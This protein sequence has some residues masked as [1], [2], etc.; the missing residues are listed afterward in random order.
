MENLFEK[1][2]NLLEEG[3]SRVE[4]ANLLD[5]QKSVVN[6]YANPRNWEKFKSKQQTQT[7]RLNFEETIL[8]V[9]DQA[10]SASNICDLIGIHHTNVN[11]QRVLKFLE[12]KGINPK[13]KEIQSNRKP[14]GF[15]TKETIFTENSTYQRSRLK[16]KLIEFKIKENKCEICGNTHWLEQPIPLQI[17]HINGINNDNRVENLQILCPNC[18]ALTD[19]YCGKNINIESIQTDN[20]ETKIEHEPKQTIDFEESFLKEKLY[21]A[22]FKNF[23]DLAK[24]L[25]ISRKTLQ[26]ICRK[27]GLP[28]S[29][30]EMGLISK[31][32]LQPVVCKHC[33][34][35]FRPAR[36]DANYCSIACFRK[37]NN[38]PEE[39]T[40]IP[41]DILLLE[42]LKHKSMLSLAKTFG[43]K[44]IRYQCK[45]H[46]LPTSIQELQQLAKQL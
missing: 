31:Q 3:K 22:E 9:L 35:I 4:I 10:T 14:Q 26:K 19:N 16:D 43:F 33:G 18:H 28:G 5:C 44:D 39:G 37:A 13:W 2:R 34:K 23:D 29:K 40:I 32:K 41:K 12:E 7:K 11:I 15:W 46:K 8:K 30:T 1:V 27:K 36:A 21:S 42:S 17:H 6:Y 25:G 24:E 38:Q 20:N 45:N